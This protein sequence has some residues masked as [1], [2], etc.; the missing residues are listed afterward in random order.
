MDIAVALPMRNYQADELAGFANVAENSAFSCINVG[1]RLC[2]DDH[3]ALTALSVLAGMTQRVRLMTGVLVLPVHD[4]VVLAKRAASLDILSNGRLVLG[5]GVGS[6]KPDFDVT[7]ADWHTRGIRTEEQI[8]IMRRVWSGEP[9]YP[10]T[11]PVAPQPPRGRP[12]IIIGGF[13]EPALRRAGRI[14]DG[15]HSFDFSPDPRL[16]EERYRIIKKAW[17]ESGRAGKPRLIASTFFSLGPNAREIY[18]QGMAEFYGYTEE[19]RR[20]AMA[21]DALTTPGAIRDSVKRFE[22]A[23]VDEVLFATAHHLGPESWE[24]LADALA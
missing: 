23:G 5:V 9:P 15:F 12:P 10:G 21:P 14:A 3:E 13:S 24:W 18:E 22:D 19:M 17:D 20:W 4:P 7:G 16:H 6:R 2:F 8:A 11:E 1:E